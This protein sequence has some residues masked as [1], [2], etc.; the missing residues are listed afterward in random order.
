[1]ALWSP[2]EKLNYIYAFMQYNNSPLHLDFWQDDFI[3]SKKKYICILKSRR[4]GYSFATAL[5]GLVKAMDGERTNY[6]KQFVSYNEADALEKIRYAAA[7]YNSIPKKYRKKIVTENKSSLEF[8]DKNGKTTSRL[9][10]LPCRP[11][12][13]KGGDIALDEQAIYHPKLSKTI[14]Q[15]ALFCIARGGCIEVGSTPLGTVG[16]FYDICSDEFKFPDYERYNIAWWYSQALCN[17]VEKAIDL[18]D[19]MTTEERVYSFGTD[20][21]KSIFQNATLDDFQQEC[22]CTFI[23]SASSYISLDL[24]YKNTPGKRECDIPSSTI[25]DEEYFN[26]SLDVDINHYTEADDLIANYNPQKHGSPLFL[27]YD[28]ARTRDAIAFYIIGNFNGKKKSV[29]KIEKRDKSFEWQKDIFRKLMRG[30]PIYRSCMDCTGMGLPL[31]EELHKEFGERIEGVNFNMQSKEMLAMNVKFSLERNDFLLAN[32][33][34]FHSQIHSIKRVATSGGSFRYD[35][36]RNEKGHADSFWAWALANH[37]ATE[38]KQKTEDFY[39]QYAR[40][41]NKDVVQSTIVEE[42]KTSVSL[43]KLTTKK[44]GKSLSSVLRRMPNV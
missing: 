19:M 38:K 7:F 20:T 13:G 17:N 14:Y 26:L 2:D 8:L 33:R 35:A 40:K 16:M 11:P 43:E 24:I 22:E 6:V 5:K 1:M 4:T 32:D 9:I 36:D 42:K 30:L 28:V 10:S 27:G 12:R 15:A 3:K 44:K 18:A 31:F 25:S 23:D 41:K 34:D 21:L 39:H 37:A 29:L